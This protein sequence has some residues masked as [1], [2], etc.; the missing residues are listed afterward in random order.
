MSA[1]IFT[2]P[3]AKLYVQHWPENDKDISENEYEGIT[4]L[5]CSRL[6]FINRKTG[7]LLS[8]R[9]LDAGPA[10]SDFAR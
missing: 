10:S 5:A 6:H 3:T 2:C 9:A 1:F 7:E 8:K 4:R